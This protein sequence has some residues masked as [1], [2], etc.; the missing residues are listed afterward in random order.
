[1]SNK[2][3][4]TD[5]LL[6]R[7]HMCSDPMSFNSEIFNQGIKENKH[8]KSSQKLLILKSSIW[9]WNNIEKDLATFVCIFC[10][11]YICLWWL[12]K[13]VTGIGYFGTLHSIIDLASRNKHTTSD[14]TEGEY[15]VLC[16]L[17][18][19]RAG[20]STELASPNSGSDHLSQSSAPIGGSI[21]VLSP[22]WL[23]VLTGRREGKHPVTSPASCSSNVML[24]DHYH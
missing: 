5:N 18:T 20:S 1:M 15:K 16:P 8:F 6:N 10:F 3:T 22:D 7:Q 19:T 12:L 23:R 11:V 9:K 14:R 4:D 2:S 17:S 24:Q 21:P 13:F